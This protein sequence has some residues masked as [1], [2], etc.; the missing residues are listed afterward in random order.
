MF[1]KIADSKISFDT[2]I[3]VAKKKAANIRI[4]EVTG[5]GTCLLTDWK[6]E[7][8]EYFEPDYE[9]IIY[10]SEEEALNKVDFLLDIPKEREKIAINRQQ[11]TLKDY[12]LKQRIEEV[13]KIILKYLKKE[14][15]LA[16]TFYLQR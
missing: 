9:V 2:H 16:E 4:Y 14:N 10:K 8:R 5:I 13:N 11:R 15:N 7:I 6:E 12:T 1:Q 3:D